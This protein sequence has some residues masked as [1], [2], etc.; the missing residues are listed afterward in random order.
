MINSL[1]EYEALLDGGL[2]P[3]MCRAFDDF[4]VVILRNFVSTEACAALRQ[5]ALELVDE[6]A[7]S[8]VRSVFSSADDVHQADDYFVES[9]DKIRFFLE[10]GAF[11]EVGQLRQAKSDS[12]NKIGHAMH[13]LDPVFDAFS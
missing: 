7:P 3:E 5:R 8:E 13:D 10:K 9:G 12:L 1:P 4:G 11:D 2:S 6:F